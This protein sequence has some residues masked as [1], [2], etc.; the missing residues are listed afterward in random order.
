MTEEIIGTKQ[1]LKAV[2]DGKVKKV[3]IASNCPDDIK[4][5]IPKE[6]AENFE[7]NEKQL[8]TRLGKPFPVAMV[9]YS[10]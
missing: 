7:G 3:V 8:G 5:K 6:L 4:A 1:I 9:G 10:D 2:S